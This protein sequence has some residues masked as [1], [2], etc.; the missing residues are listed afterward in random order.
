MNAVEHTK[1]SVYFFCKWRELPIQWNIAGPAIGIR[2][3]K[4]PFVRNWKCHSAMGLLEFAVF[5]AECLAACRL[6]HDHATIL[7]I[8]C[9]QKVT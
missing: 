3:H 5:W 9:D 1:P 7:E 8:A 6:F 2:S 4:L